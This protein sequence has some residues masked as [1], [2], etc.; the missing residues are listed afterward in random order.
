MP[1]RQNTHEY[2][3]ADKHRQTLTHHLTGEELAEKK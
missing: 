3:A 1:L 2:F